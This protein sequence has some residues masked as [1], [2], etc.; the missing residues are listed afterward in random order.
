MVGSPSLSPPVG[1]GARGPPGVSRSSTAAR[2]SVAHAGRTINAHLRTALEW[3]D[4]ACVVP[5]CTVD[6]HLEIDHIRPLA[7][8]G[9]TT[10]DN[11][12]S[13][14]RHHHARTTHDGYRLTGP[15]P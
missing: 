6:H 12:A 2:G 10:L 15:D 11:L 1:A 14:C 5:G 9:R 3:R 8:H 13:L 4:P 7:E